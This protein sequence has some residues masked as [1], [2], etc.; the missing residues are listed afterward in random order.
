MNRSASFNTDRGGSILSKNA[1]L[2]IIFGLLFIL[3]AIFP[4]VQEI[5]NS[6]VGNLF[7]P[8]IDMIGLAGNSLSYL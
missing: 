7:G 6:T 1:W 5:I 2:L 8:V 4:P 3:Y